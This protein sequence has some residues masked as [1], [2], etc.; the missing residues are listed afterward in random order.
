MM[1]DQTGRT[2]VVTGANSGLGYHITE[3][4]ARHGA[5]VVMACRDQ[6][7]GEQARQQLAG[8]VPGEQLSVRTLD[9]ADLDSVREFA[10]R[11][12]RDR[13]DLLVNN[14][15]VMAIPYRETAQGFEAQMGTNHLG[16]FALTG[17][18]LPRLIA[19]GSARVVT[20]S[21]SAH[22]S[23][24]VD[25]NNI[26]SERGYRKWRA[27]GSSKLANLLFAYE[28]DRR[29]GAAGTGLLSVAAHPG[30]AATNLQRRG[31]ELAG[32]H[33][34]VQV[35]RISN[36]LFGQSAAMGVLPALYAAT[37]PDVS[38]GEYYGP[39]RL[40][41]SRGYPER[42][43]S[44]RPSYDRENAVRLWEASERLTGVTYPWP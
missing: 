18:L 43:R 6:H 19:A 22:R 25:A 27:Y 30:Y 16:H 37:M 13:I 4:L 39:D 8:A 38:G 7:R 21:S 42:A 14:A 26:N 5:D 35:S 41:H 11:L 9:L 10:D 40:F 20:M 33:L 3:A 17:L 36:R 15:G 2:V 23:G 44:S 1:P 28:L 12:D 24:R 31:P 34:G 29:A 32:N